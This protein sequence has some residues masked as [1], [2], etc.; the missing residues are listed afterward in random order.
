MCRPKIKQK[1]EKPSTHKSSMTHA[2]NV[3]VT[4]NLDLWPFDPRTYL[5]TFVCQVWWS[6]LHRFLKYRADNRQTDK[7]RRKPDPAIDVCVGNKT[8]KNKITNKSTVVESRFMS[9]ELFLFCAWTTADRWP[10][11]WV[12]RPLYVSQLG[13]LSLS[14]SRCR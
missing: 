11:T 14:S 7:G 6:Q 12:N 8:K 4:R 10:L 2:G 13:Q 3:V 1:L 9:G 5:G